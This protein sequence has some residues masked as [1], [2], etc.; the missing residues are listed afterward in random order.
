MPRAPVLSSA[1]APWQGV[2]LEQ[3]AGGEVEVHDVAPQHHV[4]LVQ[5]ARTAEIELKN[6]AE[7]F[8]TVRV[9]PGQV[10]LFPALTPVSARTRDT[11]E[12]IAVTLDPKFVQCAA[13]SLLNG[14]GFELAPHR[15]INDAVLRALCLA[16]KAEVEAGCPGGSCYGES[17]ATSLAVH[18]VRHYATRPSAAREPRGGLA[19]YQ[20]RRVLDYMQAHL[21]EDMPL[22][23]LAEAAGLSPFH[24]ARLFKQSTGL[25]P[26]Q[27]LIQRRV[28]RAK[29]LLLTSD[30]AIADIAVRV[31][32][33]DQSHFAAH[34]KRLYGITP[35]AFLRQVKPR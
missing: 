33:C 34:F 23:A 11:G 10:C 4:V 15:P 30:A 18:L 28:E 22:R 25:A 29:G 13:H 3:H 16:L 24:F 12:F 35:K 17:L 31:G 19:H 32:F 14:E 1:A 9:R 6:G 5:L 27:Y 8:H 26:H 21:T 2:L 7:R 20:L